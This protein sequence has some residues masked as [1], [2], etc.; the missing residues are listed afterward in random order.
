MV[1]SSSVTV[2]SL[3]LALAYAQVVQWGIAKREPL[4]Q[5]NL[6]RRQARSIEEII[7]N[8]KAN[9]GY[10]ATCKIGTPGQDVT[11][12]LDTGSS[13]IWVPASDSGV[14]TKGQSSKGCL[15]GSY[16]AAI[17]SSFADA[18]EGSFSI[19][20][21]DGSSAHGDYFT[22]VFEIGDTAVLNMTIGLGQETNIPYGLVGVGYIMNE[23][24]LND[25]YP[26]L[27]VQMQKEGLIPTVAYSLWLN[28]LDAST[29][30][31][32]F[33]GIDTEKYQGDLTRIQVYKDPRSKMYTSFLVALTSLQAVSDTGSDFLSSA[34]FPISV[35]LDSGT[36]LSYLPTDL[37]Q[38]IWQEV[39]AQWSDELNTAVLP[40]SLGDGTAG[41]YFSFG[42]AGAGGPVINVT[43]DELVLPL[44]LGDTQPTFP[45][46]SG[47]YAG[48]TACRFGIQNFSSSTGATPFLLGDTF[49]RSA[50][51]V[52]DLVNN[53]VGLA[54]TDFNATESNVVPFA[55]HGA[56]MPSATAAPN[57]DALGE[58]GDGPN[59][60]GEPSYGASDGFKEQLNAA[61]SVVAVTVLGWPQLVVVLG[62]SVSLV[63]L[64]S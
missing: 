42:F 28:D 35:V 36:T 61:S 6:I 24:S 17:S 4:E 51:V 2:W 44:A 3:T 15:L 59:A 30:N 22:D 25:R 46:G 38:E 12:Q 37:A 8:D 1:L 20:Y 47:P 50:Y 41:G 45:E 34:A 64:S 14:C 63:F 62:A 40:C 31:I 57:Q 5:S 27:P 11:L 48:Q 13:D 7:T 56:T 9:G 10:F 60:S 58:G 49:L 26:N 29:G 23:A 53:E 54:P 21:V 16:T 33:G 52:Y 18:G 32:L 39:G 43:M 55:S 19:S